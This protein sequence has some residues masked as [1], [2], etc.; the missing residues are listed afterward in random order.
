MSLKQEALLAD[1][2]SVSRSA[3]S[4]PGGACPDALSSWN[5]KRV[6][7]GG[8]MLL[9][10]CSPPRDARPRAQSLW[11]CPEC[12]S[13]WEKAPEDGG[14][15]DFDRSRAVTRADWI[16]LEAGMLQAS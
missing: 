6:I 4:S 9:H 10:T 13:I 15:F 8:R 3:G 16:L 1:E 7:R 5:H 14:L 2:R 12:G 11:L